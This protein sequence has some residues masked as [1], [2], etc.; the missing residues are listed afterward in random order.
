MKKIVLIIVGI[1][2]A[3]TL[4]LGLFSAGLVVGN[5][6]FSD[7]VNFAETVEEI[8]IISDLAELEEPTED[9]PEVPSAAPE[10]GSPAPEEGEVHLEIS[11]P[12]KNLEE[13]FVPFWESWDIIHEHFVE[14]PIDDVALMEGAIYGVL[15]AKEIPTNT[16]PIEAPEVV[17]FISASGTPEDL[18]ELFEPFWGTWAISSPVDDQLVIQGAIRGML[19]SLGDPHTSYM[20]PTDYEAATVVHKG[21]E[22]YEGIG[23]WVDISKDYLTIITPFPD[24]P[25]QKSGLQPGDKIL[26]IDGEDLTGMDGELVRQKVLGPAGTT[27]TM[28]IDRTGMDIF[29]V[30]VTRDS[31]TVPS[32]D[33][34][35]LENDVAYLRLFLFGDKT[36]DEVEEALEMLLKEEPVGLILDL[37][38]NGGGAVNSAVKIAS[39]FLDDEVIFY[40]VFGDGSEEV[41]ETKGRGLATDIPMVIIVNDG[42]ASASEIV[43][44]A[45][46]DH[47]RAPIVGT[48]TF[49]KG[50]VQF[51]IP[52]SNDQGAVRVTIASWVTPDRRQ[53]HR[54]GLDPDFPIIGIPQT[55]IDEGYDIS[56]L[57]LEPDQII[58][59]DENDLQSG[60]DVQLEKAI[61]ILLEQNAKELDKLGD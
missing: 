14:Q 48:T 27:I 8:P 9:P 53:I 59:L 36:P 5:L 34:R 41:Y 47:E 42:S 32:V 1:M 49:G 52:L 26:A 29:D 4:M 61:E 38:Y 37:R 3:C 39:E 20:N 56:T 22:Q 51:W 13:L 16:L 55:T 44:G 60:R 24:S 43:A 2:L 28:T 19:D 33:G 40:E 30:D 58:I 12:A 17:D 31:V 11:Q 46:Q 7:K 23:A 10:E 25:A 57:E 35:M 50:S 21:E 18:Q 45:I 6:F 15:V 54:I